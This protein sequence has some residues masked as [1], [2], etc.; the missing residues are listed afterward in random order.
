MCLTCFL[1]FLPFFQSFFPPTMPV[2]HFPL[3]FF[4]LIVYRSILQTSSFPSL[5]FIFFY[6]LFSSYTFFLYYRIYY[7]SP[8]FQTLAKRTPTRPAVL[9]RN[10]TIWILQR[11]CVFNMDMNTFLSSGV[12]PESSDFSGL[13]VALT[14]PTCLYTDATVWLVS[15]SRSRGKPHRANQCVCG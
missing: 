3:Y 10:E 8:R 12:V 4:F 7:K 15:F 11:Y 2:F 5:F 14:R 6:S 13:C 1:H 9:L